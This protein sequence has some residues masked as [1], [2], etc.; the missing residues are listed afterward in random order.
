M[1][2][3]I[4]LIRHLNCRHLNVR[5]IKAI[6]EGIHNP[7]NRLITVSTCLEHRKHNSTS[8]RRQLWG[9]VVV[10]KLIAKP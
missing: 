7:R 2:N 10:L 3:A 9:F 8:G 5:D 1:G 6:V 4:F